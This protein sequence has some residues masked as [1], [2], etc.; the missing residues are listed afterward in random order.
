VRALAY[1]LDDLATTRSD[2]D[3]STNENESDFV[4]AHP[5]TLADLSSFPVAEPVISAPDS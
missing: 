5:A 2:S 3:S 4:F 1:P